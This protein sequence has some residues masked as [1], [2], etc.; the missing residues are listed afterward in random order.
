MYALLWFTLPEVKFDYGFS[1]DRSSFVYRTK[2]YPIFADQ[3]F[4]S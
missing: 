1:T 4:M 3:S 2:E